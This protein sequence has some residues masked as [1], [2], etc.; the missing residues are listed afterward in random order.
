MFINSKFI[1]GV[2]MFCGGAA[3]VYYPSHTMRV[4]FEGSTRANQ[5][6]PSFSFGELI[7]Q[8]MD[9]ATRA[10][11][12]SADDYTSERVRMT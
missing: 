11:K 2:L 10:I 7:Q 12:E 8:Q 5:Q 6:L 4:A 9:A 3:G 1:L